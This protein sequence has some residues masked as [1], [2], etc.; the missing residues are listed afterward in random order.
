MA[1]Q[2]IRTLHSFLHENHTIL[3]SGGTVK[4]YSHDHAN[5][6]PI[7]CMVHG[8]PQSSY[9]WRHLVAALKD[10]ISLFVVELPGYGASSLPPQHDK[11]T[12]GNL[13]IEALHRVFDPDRDVIWCG[14]DRG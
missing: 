9:I 12:V 5:G 2:T 7:L 3:S 13:I 4:S 14:H 11:R 8:W 6:G 10:Q 1:D